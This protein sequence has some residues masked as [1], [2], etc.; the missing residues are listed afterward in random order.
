MKLI[1]NPRA[2]NCAIEGYEMDDKDMI[3]ALAICELLGQSFKPA[4]I[5]RAFE[6]VREKYYRPPRPPREAKISHARRRD[7]TE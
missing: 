6:K 7:E 5:E 3:L 4:E 1:P 2:Y